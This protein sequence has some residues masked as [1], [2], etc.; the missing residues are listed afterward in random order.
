MEIKLIAH[1]KT[2]INA[3]LEKVWDALVNPIMIKEY[4]FGTTVVSDWKEGSQILWGGEWNGKSYEDT[5]TILEFKEQNTLQYSHFSP[6]SGKP[7]LPENYHIV[8]IKITALKKGVEV[9]LTQDNNETEKEQKHSEGNWN[10]MLDGLK[11]FLEN[12]TVFANSAV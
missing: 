9:A 8:T 11:K 2:V 12:H 6:L 7:D 4:M 5:G 10:A 1:V 3:P